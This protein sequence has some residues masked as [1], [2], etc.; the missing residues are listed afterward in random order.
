MSLAIFNYNGRQYSIPCNSED[1]LKDICNKFAI[2]S[3]I[4]LDSVYFV[5]NGEKIKSELTFEKCVNNTD[6]IRN[7]MNILVFPMNSDE[8][9]NN[10]EHLISSKDIICPECGECSKININDYRISLYDCK[11]KHSI[12]KLTLKEFEKTQFIDESKIICDN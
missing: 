10:N 5:Y 1:K 11:N 12:N 6:K 3:E 7:K 4:N 2:K 8:D 9:N